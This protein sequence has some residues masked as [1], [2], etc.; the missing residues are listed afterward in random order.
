[1]DWEQPARERE[2]T[3]GLDIP[4]LLL[5]KAIFS[6]CPETHPHTS[7]TC[8]VMFV[9]QKQKTAQNMAG[10]SSGSYTKPPTLQL[11]LLPFWH[12]S[13]TSLASDACLLL[14]IIA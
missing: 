14:S 2:E 11:V 6:I 13:P 12:L 3:K 4:G 9:A 10:S 7:D 8:C 1:M 5:Y